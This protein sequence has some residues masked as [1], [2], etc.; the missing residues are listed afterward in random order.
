MT[1]KKT[2]TKDY[3]QWKC[4]HYTHYFDELA[5]SRELTSNGVHTVKNEKYE[6]DIYTNKINEVDSSLPLLVFFN[7]A[8]SNREDKK[9]PFFSGIS[10]S[11]QLGL[12]ILSFSDPTVDSISELNLAWYAGSSTAPDLRERIILLINLFHRVT[13]RNIILLGGSGGGFAALSIVDSLTCPTLAIVWNPQTSI[14]LYNQEAVS[15]YLKLALNCPTDTNANAYS[16]LSDNNII[17][18]L[19]HHRKNN[20]SRILYLQNRTDWHLKSHALPYAKSQ[21]Y[22]ITKNNGCWEN[23]LYIY[24]GDFGTGHAAPSREII[25]KV[26]KLYVESLDSSIPDGYIASDEIDSMPFNFS[27][28][29]FDIKVTK[30][31]TEIIIST[32]IKSKYPFKNPLF[33]FYFMYK[34]MK[35]VQEYSK[36]NTLRIPLQNLNADEIQVQAF[37]LDDGHRC[38]KR[39]E[40]KV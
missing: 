28:D 24:L 15:R 4:E 13:N 8:V 19:C 14:S 35:N 10:I 2:A 37:I 5:N 34:G 31:D 40:L 25:D 3:T 39:I 11:N 16:H 32:Q 33:A 23:N 20:N 26:I 36:N 30:K 21:N 1:M 9:G 22:K 29:D 38:F 18:D 17:H 7:G 12:P 27:T 6:I